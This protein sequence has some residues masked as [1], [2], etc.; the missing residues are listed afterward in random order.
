M[1]SHPAPFLW[2]HLPN[3]T[4]SASTYMSFGRNSKLIYSTQPFLLR[5]S[6]LSEILFSFD[7]FLY[8]GY[9]LRIIGF[10]PQRSGVAKL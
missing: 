7:C 9:P 10:E 8:S 2:N 5:L 1:F 4:R 3:T 6:S